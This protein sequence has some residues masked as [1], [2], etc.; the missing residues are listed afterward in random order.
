MEDAP[1]PEGLRLKMLINAEK[2]LSI[3]STINFI[4]LHIFYSFLLLREF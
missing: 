3:A 2:F 4:F 1:Y